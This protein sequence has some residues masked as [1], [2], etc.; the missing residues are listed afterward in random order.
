MALTSLETREAAAFFHTYKRLKL[1]IERGE[2]VY[3]Y[4]RDG[5]KYLDMFA[6]LAVNALGYN[7]PAVNAAIHA[8]LRRYIH[9][10]N[11]FYQDTQIEFA[12]RLLSV[13]GYSRV[14]LTNSGTE[15]IE[16]ALKLSRKWGRRE[17]RERIYGLTGSFHG[18]TL[19]A[20]SIT[21]RE[22]YRT[23]FDPF[24]PDVGFL[25]F[26]DV[27]D[28]TRHVDSKTLAVVVEFIQGEGGVNELSADYVRA[29]ESLRKQH[30][31]LLIADEIQSGAG[32]T[33]KFFAF[34]HHAIRPDIVVLA[35]A[36][37]GGLPLGAILASKHLA[38]VLSPG[39]HGTTFGGNPVACAAGTAV[40]K[41]IVEGGVM[42]NAGSVGAQLVDALNS[43][44]R[45]FPEIVREVRGKGLML[46]LQLN[47]DATPVMEM[48][49]EAGVLVNV[50]CGSVLR[51][52]PPLI[53]SDKH[54]DA[55]TQALRGALRA[56]TSKE[57]KAISNSA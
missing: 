51:L 41:E 15:A 40:M 35:K 43:V 39:S 2:G 31:F 34:E 11:Y 52:L 9:L 30:A 21:D 17:E 47:A 5:R 37:G 18:R 45:E 10:S 38:E 3:L 42:E 8:Q 29:L 27:E 16:G 44:A 32:R 50:T 13:T 48:M 19:G 6:G 4:A 54:I 20:L 14:F 57:T 53:I 55:T 56:A 26:N 12:E 7:H 22:S 46:G 33:G 1:D 25:R 23:G 28:V 36:I 24:L 49:L